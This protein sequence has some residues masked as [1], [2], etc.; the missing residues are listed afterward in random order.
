MS[1]KT[2]T[3]VKQKKTR[4]QA[5]AVAAAEDARN[6]ITFGDLEFSLEKNLNLRI[7]LAVE[8]TTDGTVGTREVLDLFVNFVNRH[9]LLI[10]EKPR[11]LTWVEVA[12]QGDDYEFA[13]F[14]MAWRERTR[15]NAVSG[16]KALAAE[17][18]N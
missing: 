17:S 11:K 15:P 1:D 2:K 6:R 7:L 12:E 9:D 14:I 16:E 5:A 10:S 3:E 13:Q 8:G 4:E 18:Q